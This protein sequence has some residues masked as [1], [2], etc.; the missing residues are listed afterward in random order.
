MTLSEETTGGLK[1]ISESEQFINPQRKLLVW[2]TWQISL[3]IYHH[4]RQVNSAL[5]VC[6][7]QSKFWCDW[8]ALLPPSLPAVPV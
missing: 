3:D 7:R 6:R 5:F 4:C 1:T 2:F 8:V